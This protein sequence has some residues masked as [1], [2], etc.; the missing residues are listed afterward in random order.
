M[1]ESIPHIGD[2]GK[3]HAESRAGAPRGPRSAECGHQQGREVGEGSAG[4]R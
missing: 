4:V 1:N 2:A 3:C